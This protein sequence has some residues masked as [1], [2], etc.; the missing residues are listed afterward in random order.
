MFE[1]LTSQII[2]K[3][4]YVNELYHR[5][6][7]VVAPSGSG[8]TTAL[9]NVRE[10]TGAPM[11]NVN[12]ELSKRLLDLTERQRILH[13][14]R[15]LD[16]ILTQTGSNIILLDNIEILFDVSLRQDPLRLLQGLSRNRTLV[17]AWNGTISKGNIIYAVPEH[18]EYRKY[19]V[20]DLLVI[21]P[22]KAIEELT[23]SI[24]GDSR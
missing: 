24:K 6:I 8:K 4:T 1:D 23:K 10:K 16:E 18:P 12:I 14:P 7:L 20:Q 22:S 11:V 9:L 5:L 2:Q 3:L 19:E 21:S 17:V 13:I 15:L